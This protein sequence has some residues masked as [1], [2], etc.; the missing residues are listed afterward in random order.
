M[1]ETCINRACSKTETLLRRTETFDP[2]CFLYAFVFRVSKA[3]IVKRTLLKTENYFHPLDKKTTCLTWTQ[4]K[5]SEI[6]EKQRIKLDIFVN[7][8][9]KKCFL[10]FKTIFFLI[11]FCSFEA[12]RYF[13]VELCIFVSKLLSATNQQLFAS[14][15]TISHMDLQTV[16]HH[17]I[18]YWFQ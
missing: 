5:I 8:I 6:S 10:N 9:K 2:I 3:K 18:N 15:K 14:L 4:I 11:S 7:F 16:P 1:C 13:W 17:S 12:L